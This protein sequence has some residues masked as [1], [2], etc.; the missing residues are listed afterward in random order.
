MGDF[1]NVHEQFNWYGSCRKG[2]LYVYLSVVKYLLEKCCDFSFSLNGHFHFQCLFSSCFIAFLWS[3]DL[4][5]FLMVC[6]VGHIVL[7]ILKYP[8]IP[9][10]LVFSP[11]GS[12]KSY[13]VCWVNKASLC[14]LF[15]CSYWCFFLIISNMGFSLFISY[16]I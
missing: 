7:V 15:D 3:E 9:T 4:W 5:H 13:N 14:V 10:W 6:D 12:M 2:T 1:L 16:Y 8:R 11:V